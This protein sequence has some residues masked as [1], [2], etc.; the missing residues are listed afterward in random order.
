MTEKTNGRQSLIS[1]KR[2]KLQQS[3]LNTW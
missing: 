3:C 2:Q 1:L